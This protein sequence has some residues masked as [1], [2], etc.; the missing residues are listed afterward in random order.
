MIKPHMPLSLRSRLLANDASRV[1]TNKVMQLQ[2]SLHGISPYYHK[3]LPDYK[4]LFWGIPCSIYEH[5]LMTWTSHV[6]LS[7]WW[8]LLVSDNIGGCT[9]KEMHPWKALCDASFMFRNILTNY[10]YLS[11]GVPYYI[12]MY[13]AIMIQPH[14][15]A[16]HRHDLLEGTQIKWCTLKSIVWIICVD[17]QDNV[18]TYYKYLFFFYMPYLIISIKWTPALLLWLSV[19]GALKVT[20]FKPCTLRSMCLIHEILTYHKSL[21]YGGHHVIFRHIRLSLMKAPCLHPTEHTCL[22]NDSPGGCTSR[23]THPWGVLCNLF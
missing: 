15:T 18:I 2:K 16:S 20:Q 12:H 23:V 10:N 4:C 5:I 6:L 8:S 1:C 22:V 17:V 11:V 9:N 19:N 7:L 14:M 3:L 21:S 13:I